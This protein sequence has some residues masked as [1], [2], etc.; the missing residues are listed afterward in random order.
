MELNQEQL[1]EVQFMVQQLQIVLGTDNDARKGAEEHLKKIKEGEPDKYACYLTAVIIDATASLEIKAL[2][3]VVLRRSIGSPL[4][5]KENKTLWEVLSAQARDYLKD[6]LLKFNRTITTKDLIHKVSN[7][8]VEVAGGMY[9][10]EN[11]IVW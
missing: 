7:L 5:S 3:S 6:N 10:Y 2:A 9:E 4:P 8:L 11:E 1:A